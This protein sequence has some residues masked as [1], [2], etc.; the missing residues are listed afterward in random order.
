MRVRSRGE[1]RWGMSGFDLHHGRIIIIIVILLVTVAELILN[2]PD[3]LRFHRRL[4]SFRGF[5]FR[6]LCRRKV[7]LDTGEAIEAVDLFANDL[8][9]PNPTLASAPARIMT[10]LITTH[11]GQP[12]PDLP[13]RP[14]HHIIDHVED[15]L[16][17]L[18]I[19]LLTD[20]T[21]RHQLPHPR[22]VPLRPLAT[23][24]VPAAPAS[25]VTEPAVDIRH[26]HVGVDL[27]L[28]A[29]EHGGKGEEDVVVDPS[30]EGIAGF[31]GDFAFEGDRYGC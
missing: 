16:D 20:E 1:Y 23:H 21:P 12:A 14:P 11:L 8:Q 18:L 2:T 29:D 27:E 17:Q 7:E 9:E 19:R 13:L 10:I 28:L 6:L 31:N 22:P 5:P 15:L 26:G 3:R 30:A 4:L 24:G 25:H